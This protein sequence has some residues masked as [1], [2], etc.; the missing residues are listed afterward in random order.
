[1]NSD[2]AV[3]KSRRLPQPA[4]ILDF[5]WYPFATSLDPA[6]FCFVAS[7]RETPVKLLDAADGRVS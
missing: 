1:M 4:P 5:A 7:V 3:F 6:S 2:I